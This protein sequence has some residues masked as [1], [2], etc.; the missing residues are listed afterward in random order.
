MKVTTVTIVCDDPR[1]ARGKVARIDTLQ[2]AGASWVSR[3]DTK[4]AVEEFARPRPEG[5][6]WGSARYRPAASQA[7]GDR[8]RYRCKLCDRTLECTEPTLDWLLNAVAE[9]GV[10]EPTLRLLNELVSRRT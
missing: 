4:S 8:R 1:H 9:Q 3:S 6:T 10:S 7:G 2:L 5:K